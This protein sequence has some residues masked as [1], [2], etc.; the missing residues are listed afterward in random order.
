MTKPQAIILDL[1]GTLLRSDGSVSEYTLS[2]LDRCKVC[3]VRIIVATARFWF[4]AEKYLNII[5]PDYAILADGTQIYRGD[6]M[7]AGFPMDNRQSCGI[8]TEL[9]AGDFVVSTGKSL[10]CSRSGIYEPW[11]NTFDFASGLSDPVYKIAAVLDSAN[12]A[13]EMA[14][15]YSCRLLTYRDENLYGFICCDTGKFRAVCALADMLG[16]NLQ[17]TIAFGDDEN[18]YDMLKNCGTGVAVANGIDSIRDVADSVTYSNDDD[19]VAAYL[20][21]TVLN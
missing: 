20:E 2:I 5:Q 19:G 14:D 12:E 3:G 9:G 21:H 15:R 6:E 8:I 17:D 11:R 18:D 7:I 4:K 1:D 13:R 16:I 10:L